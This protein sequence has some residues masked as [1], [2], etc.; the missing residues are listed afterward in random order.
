MAESTSFPRPLFEGFIERK[1]NWKDF[2]MRPNRIAALVC[3]ILA[4]VFFW[5]G[6][7]TILA[8]GFALAAVLLVFRFI[9]QGLFGMIIFIVSLV[10]F[11]IAIIFF[12]LYAIDLLIFPWS[13]LVIFL[14]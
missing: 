14:I 3:L 10:V 4:I 9:H 12:V 1:I 7:S 11:V 8:I 2:N 5:F 6:W 13:W